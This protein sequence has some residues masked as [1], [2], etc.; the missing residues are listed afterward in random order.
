VI[1]QNLVM[2]IT[3][4]EEKDHGSVVERRA[5]HNANVCFDN[6][7]KARRKARQESHRRH[8]RVHHKRHQ[9]CRLRYS[10]EFSLKLGSSGNAW[11]NHRL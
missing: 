6:I 7:D 2:S 8:C 10:L 9:V 1:N 3:Y 5:I 4:H 11:F